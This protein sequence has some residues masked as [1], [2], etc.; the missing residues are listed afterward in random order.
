MTDNTNR[1]LTDEEVAEK[2]ADLEATYQLLCEF[3]VQM[4]FKGSS[5]TGAMAI[6]LFELAAARGL[7]PG[8]ALHDIA[9]IWDSIK[10]AERV[11]N[12]D[13]GVVH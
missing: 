6:M 1:S 12:R 8:D 13:K 3:C 5:L 10:I 4:E 2:A 9:S 11:L 7:E